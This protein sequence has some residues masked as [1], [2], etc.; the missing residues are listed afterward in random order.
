M[1][2]ILCFAPGTTNL[3]VTIG[4]SGSNLATRV[5]AFYERLTFE[6]FEVTCDNHEIARKLY[7]SVPDTFQAIYAALNLT[8]LTQQALFFMPGTRNH[9][10]CEVA[11][12]LSRPWAAVWRVMCLTIHRKP[13]DQIKRHSTL[14]EPRPA[15]ES[16]QM[17]REIIRFDAIRN[18]SPEEHPAGRKH[19]AIPT[20]Q[21][22]GMGLSVTCKN[23][24]GARGKE[25]LSDP[26]GQFHLRVDRLY[27]FIRGSVRQQALYAAKLEQYG[28]SILIPRK[29]PEV[30][31]KEALQIVRTE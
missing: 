7:L 15:A 29:A 21:H 13:S 6:G 19:A 25:K 26:F 23:R 1:A 18:F 11:C 2:S 8:H 5:F 10:I 4:K 12:Y 30:I 16:N 31:A 9:A 24:K 3:E 17:I 27:L 28:V 20:K 22:E 14:K